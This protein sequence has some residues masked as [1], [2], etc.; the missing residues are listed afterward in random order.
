MWLPD[1]EV[2]IS[3]SSVIRGRNQTGD[4]RVDPVLIPIP[5]PRRYESLPTPSEDVEV[6]A[7]AILKTATAEAERLVEEA[8]QAAERVLREAEAESEQ[9][10]A[11][12]REEGLQQGRQDGQVQYDALCTRTEQEHAEKMQE[13]T[14]LAE[15]IHAHREQVIR[16]AMTPLPELCMEVL[17]DLLGREL[18][19]APANIEALVQDLIQYV[20]DSTRVEVRVNPTDYALAQAA[21][22]MWRGAKYGDW[23]L[24]VIPDHSIRAGG[25]QIRSD[26]GNID[27]TL[28]VKLEMLQETLDKAFA[29]GEVEQVGTVTD[30]TSMG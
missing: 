7:E 1:L 12:A 23:D 20:V 27:A 18:E 26:V 5:Q 24:V 22:P 30:V 25:C 21:H 19:L 28:D 4:S 13:L 11:K 3:L 17:R 15:M 2:T 9:M 6:T 16:G 14:R 8:R 10:K 29:G